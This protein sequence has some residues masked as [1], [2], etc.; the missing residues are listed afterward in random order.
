MRAEC[1][2]KNAIL[3]R[4]IGAALDVAEHRGARLGMGRSHQTQGQPVA[5]AVLSRCVV[6]RIGGIVGISGGLRHDDERRAPTAG[7]QVLDVPG[8]IGQAPA[9]LGNQDHVGTAGDARGDR[10]VSGIPAHH[11]EH[12]D[13]IVTG[14]GRLQA[15]QRLGRNRHRGGMTD[16]PIGARD[17]V[18]D[19]LGNADEGQAAGLQQASKNRQ[20]A[21]AADADQPVERETAQAVQHLARAIAHSPAF[22][23]KGERIAPVGAAEERAAAPRHAGIEAVRFD[24]DG[25]DRPLE[26]PERAVADADRLPAVAMMRAQGHG[27]DHGI[28]A[29]AIAAAGQDPNSLG[30]CEP[31]SVV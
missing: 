10:D 4:R 25:C 14:A 30:H 28:E 23:G 27:P 22:H 21:V 17:V 19:G 26:Q 29:G 16:R 13:A 12:H 8:D 15:V 20:A 7:P 31:P 1:R 24:V 5:H 6:G 3:G 2:G 11:L 18:V 9:D